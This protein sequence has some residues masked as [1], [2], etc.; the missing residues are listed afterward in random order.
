MFDIIRAKG[1]GPQQAVPLIY[2][3]A[4]DR[5]DLPI[6]SQWPSKRKQIVGNCVLRG[7][8]IGMHIRLGKMLYQ[9][10]V[11]EESKLLLNKAKNN[12]SLLPDGAQILATHGMFPA[13]QQLSHTMLMQ[14]FAN[15]LGVA[16]QDVYTGSALE[17]AIV[18][19]AVINRDQK[20]T[21]YRR[22]ED[23][24]TYF[25]LNLNPENLERLT[26]YYSLLFT[27][28]I[29]RVEHVGS[30][31]V[32]ITVDTNILANEVLQALSKPEKK[33]CTFL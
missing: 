15:E 24:T 18:R 12:I 17:Q 25:E 14:K 2:Q 31:K 3:V 7:Y 29:Q 33:L 16:Y 23:G 11:S 21:H 26:D 4:P 9:F 10:L 19:T 32:K 27:R 1:K 13:V 8:S 20:N 28:L 5:P 6:V 22:N 30:G